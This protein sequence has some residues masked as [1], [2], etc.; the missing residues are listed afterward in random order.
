MKVE[1]IPVRKPTFRVFVIARLKFG[2]D[3]TLENMAVVG[4]S[5]PMKLST[6]R[7]ANGYR[8]KTVKNAINTAMVVTITGSAK[9]FFRSSSEL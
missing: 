3:I 6:S 9:N 7:I 1:A 2:M 4:P 8:M 5:S